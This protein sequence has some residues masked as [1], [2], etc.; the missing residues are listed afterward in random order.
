M[1]VDNSTVVRNLR[2]CA[3]SRIYP[4]TERFF[5]TVRLRAA[6]FLQ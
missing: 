2:V 1:S 4:E 5:S 6:H 3:A